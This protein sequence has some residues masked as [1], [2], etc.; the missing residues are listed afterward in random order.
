MENDIKS[1]WE[2]TDPRTKKEKNTKKGN[3]MKCKDRK[4]TLSS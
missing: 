1:K 3:T 4:A 2:E